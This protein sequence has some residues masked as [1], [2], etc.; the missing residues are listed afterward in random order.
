MAE[1]IERDLVLLGATA[2][3]DRLQDG[4]PEAI[5]LLSKAGIKVKLLTGCSG[6]VMLPPAKLQSLH[7]CYGEASPSSGSANRQ[8]HD[9]VSG[10]TLSAWDMSWESS[11]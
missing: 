1:E 7:S 2:V 4:V 9:Q 6:V 11:A 3:E 8:K 10:F 5:A